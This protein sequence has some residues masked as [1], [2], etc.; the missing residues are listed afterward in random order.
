MQAARDRILDAPLSSSRSGGIDALR[1]F[2]ALWVLLSHVVT[3]APVAQGEAAVPDL[4]RSCF[5][6]LAWIFQP[7]GETH[8]A[9]LGFIVLSGYCIHRA[10]FRRSAG[11]AAGY[12][13]RRGFRIYPV[14][15]LASMVGITASLFSSSVSPEAARAITGT[16][17][18]QPALIAGKLLGVS[19]F[20]PS[21]HA[22]T[23]QGN[24][25]LHTVMVEIWL[26]AAYPLLVFAFVRRFGSRALTF[27]LVGGLIAGVAAVGRSP[28][29]QGW[30]HNGSLLG[31]LPYWWLG[32]ALVD[33]DLVARLRRRAAPTILAWMLLSALL[34]VLPAPS[35]FLVEARK[36]L[37]AVLVGLLITSIDV[38]YAGR[39]S[40]AASLGRAGYSLYAFHAPVVYALLIA[41]SPWWVAVIAA[42]AAGGVAFVGVERPLDRLGRSRAA[43]R[44]VTQAAAVPL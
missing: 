23:F 16:A 6:L 35:I 9:V 36:L 31:F 42:L 38:P 12:G 25:P 41:G 28:A 30:W 15:L 2:L 13:I 27:L 26:Y 4:V 24:A 44:D 39:L 34:V 1:G 8:P 33:S 20:F 22:S 21:L 32:A 17:A 14:Y 3:W 40:R 10:G 43:R 37:F 5:K 7:A 11:N 29:I 19:A 18:I